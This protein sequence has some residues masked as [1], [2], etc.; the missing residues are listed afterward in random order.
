MGQGIAFLSHPLVSVGWKC[1][2]PQPQGPVRGVEGGCWSLFCGAF[3]FELCVFLLA[4]EE[5]VLVVELSDGHLAE[6]WL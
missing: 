1:L 2:G 6:I 5:G 3:L 4:R